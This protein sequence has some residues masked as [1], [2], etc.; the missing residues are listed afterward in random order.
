M[1]LKGGAKLE[2]S[3]CKSII[4]IT[5]SNFE[6]FETLS[7]DSDGSMGEEITYGAD[8]YISCPNCDK[9]I[10]GTFLYVEYPVGAFNFEELQSVIGANVLS[11]NLSAFY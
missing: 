4:D 1:N 2:C 8:F 9:D 7:V 5:Y 6:D 10:N 3:N 11:N